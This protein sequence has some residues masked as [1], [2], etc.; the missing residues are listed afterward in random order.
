[1]DFSCLRRIEVFGIPEHVT[2]D[3]FEILEGVAKALSVDYRREDFQYAVRVSATK[4]GRCDTIVCKFVSKRI[5]DAWLPR[6]VPVRCLVTLRPSS[7]FHV[8]VNQHILL[9]QKYILA[10][11]LQLVRSGWLKKVWVADS[12]VWVKEAF[13]NG[14]ERILSSVAD[15]IVRD[16]RKDER[17]LRKT[18]ASVK[19]SYCPSPIIHQPRPTTFSVY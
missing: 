1:M 2:G 12:N 3:V 5:R 15:P 10:C 9:E 16:C 8:I 19:S 13:G 14:R 17:I 6:G 11:A 18:F 7:V 4:R